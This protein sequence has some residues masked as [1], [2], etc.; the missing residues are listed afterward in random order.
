MAKVKQA[1]DKIHKFISLFPYTTE[2]TR[3]YKD[4]FL[5]GTRREGSNSLQNT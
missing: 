2:N 3:I 4:E 5:N 1:L